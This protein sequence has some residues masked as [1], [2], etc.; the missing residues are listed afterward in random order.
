MAFVVYRS[1]LFVI[2]FLGNPKD[3]DFPQVRINQIDDIETG[4]CEDSECT[5]GN[6]KVCSE[7]WI[8]LEIL[9]LMRGVIETVFAY[10][11]SEYQWVRS[12]VGVSLMRKAVDI[13]EKKSLKERGIPRFFLKAFSVESAKKTLESKKIRFSHPNAYNDILEGQC[14][15]KDANNEDFQILFKEKYDN[16]LSKARVCCFSEMSSENILPQ[17]AYYANDGNGIMI[18]FNVKS[19]W[20]KYAPSEEEKDAIIKRRVWYVNNVQKEECFKDNILDLYYV[21]SC[22]WRHEREWRIV[23]DVEKDVEV[24]KLDVEKKKDEN[25][26]DVM[27]VAFTNEEINCIFLGPRMSFDDAKDIFQ[28]IRQYWGKVKV[29]VI[30]GF[31]YGS[32]VNFRSSLIHGLEDLEKFYGI[33]KK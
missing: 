22:A 6:W 15:W 16:I 29:E 17:W 20:R 10:N 21:K 12:S 27:D 9:P 25:G 18:A 8:L 23:L 28:K 14:V 31:E 30:S 24:L 3:E 4:E 26:F 19:I 2:A 13:W 33:K 5:K 11:S 32:Y 7:E 1:S